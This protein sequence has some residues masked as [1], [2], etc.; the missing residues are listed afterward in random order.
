MGPLHIAIDGPVSA[1]KGTV[2]RGLAERLS[3]PYIDTGAM[4]R[5]A[6]YLAQTSG[7]SLED[8]ASVVRLVSEAKIEIR[9]PTSE[10]RD[11]RLST[12]ILNG[13]DISWKIRSEEVGFGASVVSQ[14]PQVRAILVAKQQEMARDRSVVMEGRDITTRVL[15]KAVVRIF[16][17]ASAE[18][19]AHRR[20]RQLKERGIIVPYEKVLSDLLARDR[21]D[22]TR[23]VDPLRVTKGVWVLDTTDLTVPEVLEK[24]VKYIQKKGF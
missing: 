5:A 6:A 7:I 4:Y 16:L 17:T 10:E 1:G 3:I 18:E 13:E 24:I 22:S 2:A 8:V 14:H 20:Q 9:Q 11:G 12:I 15:P 21:L 19:R 23:E